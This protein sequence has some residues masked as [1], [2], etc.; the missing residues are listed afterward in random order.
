MYDT[1]HAARQREL[2]DDFKTTYKRRAGV[3]NTFSQGVRAFDMRRSRYRGQAKTHLQNVFTAIAINIVR[4]LAWLAQPF[5]SP[6]YVSPFA[7]LSST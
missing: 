7:A 1:L 2:A 4:A 5:Y 3:E 6:P